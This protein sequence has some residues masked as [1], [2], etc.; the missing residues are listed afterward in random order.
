MFII[1]QQIEE[2]ESFKNSRLMVLLPVRLYVHHN[3]A[4]RLLVIDWQNS[5]QTVSLGII[6]IYHR[7]S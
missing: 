7:S 6:I 2:N 4:D 3:Y 5:A 1:D